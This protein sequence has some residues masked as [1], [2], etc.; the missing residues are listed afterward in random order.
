MSKYVQVYVGNDD[1]FIQSI[2]YDDEWMDY[3][4]G[5]ETLEKYCYINYYYDSGDPIVKP[6]W[7]DSFV[8]WLEEIL[9]FID[10]ISD[11]EYSTF[12]EA[13]KDLEN[14][15]SDWH[16]TKEMVLEIIAAYDY[17]YYKEFLNAHGV[18]SR[19]DD[20]EIE[21]LNDIDTETVFYIYGK[22]TNTSVD[23]YETSSMDGRERVVIDYI[24]TPEIDPYSIADFVFGQIYGV[25]IL[26]FDDD[27]YNQIVNSD[28]PTK[29]FEE[30][31]YEGDQIEFDIQSDNH[32]V[33]APYTISAIYNEY[34]DGF[35][36]V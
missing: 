15:A 22:V 17:N 25:N 12:E 10:D 28:N 33:D 29:T 31:M 8:G 3:V 18:T 11:E 21:Y 27:T 32:I 36:E 35:V 24:V 23:H 14:H 26:E 34:G 7:Y 20:Y 4:G 19:P 9:D 5:K 2:Y 30:L 1:P 16:T 6:T 13:E